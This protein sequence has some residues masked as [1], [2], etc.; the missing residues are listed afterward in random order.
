MTKLKNHT[1]IIMK[2]ADKNL[3]IA[4]MRRD[5]YVAEAL[6]IMY[7]SDSKTYQIILQ[8]SP[9]TDHKQ[10]KIYLWQPNMDIT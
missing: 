8:T 4:V 6:S 3:G 2:L 9:R 5:R 7:L 10:T 1:G